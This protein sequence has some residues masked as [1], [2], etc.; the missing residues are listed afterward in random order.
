MYQKINQYLAQNKREPLNSIDLPVKPVEAAVVVLCFK[1]GPEDHILLTKR[2]ETVAHHKGQIGLPGGVKDPVDDTLWDTALR[3]T[4]EEIGI[5]R[6]LIQY[7]GELGRVVTPTG[8]SVTPFIATLTQ[9]FNMKINPAEIAE[10]FSV[11]LP[12]LLNPQN[13]STEIKT[14]FGRDYKDPIYTY[15][16]YKIWGATGRI[17]DDMLQVWRLLSQK[18]EEF[19]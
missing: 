17:L 9:P 1:E 19:F 2:S 4:E 14:Y 15:R 7:V 11:P 8:F 13:F 18:K 10:I 5:T 6:N 12:H 3:E 16:D